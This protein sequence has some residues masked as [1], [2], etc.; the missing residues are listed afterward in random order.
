LAT[1]DH[2]DVVDAGA[3]ERLDLTF[4]EYA[5]G[6]SVTPVGGL[7]AGM[8]LFLANVAF[9]R[10]WLRDHPYGPLEWLWRSATYA[11][12]QPWHIASGAST[13]GT[14]LAE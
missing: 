11:R 5:F 8:L 7:A 9:S 4:D 10:W 12:W 1:D 14:L 3:A 13:P 6:V 2:D